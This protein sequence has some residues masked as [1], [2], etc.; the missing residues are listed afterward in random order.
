LIRWLKNHTGTNS[1][2]NPQATQV[3]IPTENQT[4]D[5]NTAQRKILRHETEAPTGNLYHELVLDTTNSTGI[6]I[7]AD[8]QLQIEK[9]RMRW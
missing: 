4:L 1:Y 9:I 6:D 3:K 7:R 8:R 2:N 5:S